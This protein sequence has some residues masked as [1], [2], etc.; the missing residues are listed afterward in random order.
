MNSLC[1]CLFSWTFFSLQFVFLAALFRCFFNKGYWLRNDGIFLFLNRLFVCDFILDS[2]SCI[3]C[4][5]GQNSCRELICCCL[6]IFVLCSS[7]FCFIEDF[8]IMDFWH[9]FQNLFT[10]LGYEIGGLFQWSCY[11]C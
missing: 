11:L 2:F 4:P 9:R 8:M 5:L 10:C 3:S 1:C 6:W 7:F